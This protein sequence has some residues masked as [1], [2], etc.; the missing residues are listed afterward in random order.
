M[1]SLEK[2]YI[3]SLKTKYQIISTEFGA[4]NVT[5][6]IIYFFTCFSYEIK[7]PPQVF[8]DGWSSPLKK[9]RQ[10]ACYDVINFRLVTV[11]SSWQIWTLLHHNTQPVSIFNRENLK[12][13]RSQN[14]PRRGLWVLLSS[15]LFRN[16]CNWGFLFFF[17]GGIKKTLKTGATLYLQ[18]HTF[19]FFRL[20]NWFYKP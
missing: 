9:L 8:L 2:L 3:Y 19:S 6:I 20:C 4:L 11:D 16:Y 14:G 17:L 10:V 5:Y 12:N 18:Q 13:F 7:S 15:K 1:F